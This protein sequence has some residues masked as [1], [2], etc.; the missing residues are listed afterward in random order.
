[1]CNQEVYVQEK[2]MHMWKIFSPM[3][4][5]CYKPGKDAIVDLTLIDKLKID[6]NTEEFP[7]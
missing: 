5:M 1:M 3:E 7:I 6:T 4:V 2:W